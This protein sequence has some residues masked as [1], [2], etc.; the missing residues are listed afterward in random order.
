MKLA[1]E[2]T[3]TKLPLAGERSKTMALVVLG[4]IWL[5]ILSV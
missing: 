3:P 4:K 2:E 5:H 1:L